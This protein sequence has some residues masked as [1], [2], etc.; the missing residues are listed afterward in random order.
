M[1]A[2]C[3]SEL[4]VLAINLINPVL[5]ELIYTKYIENII[6]TMKNLHTLQKKWKFISIRL[7]SQVK[8]KKQICVLKSMY[9]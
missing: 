8:Q 4:Q 1:I 5:I 3:Q 7:L 9:L 2:R 6:V